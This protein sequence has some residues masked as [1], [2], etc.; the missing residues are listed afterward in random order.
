MKQERLDIDR[1]AF[2]GRTY[3]EYVR[4]FG[5]DESRLRRGPILDCPAGAASFAA[6]AGR[7][8]FDV[9]ACDM[10]YDL[11]PSELLEKGERDIRLIH[12]KVGEA[13]HMYVW[14]YYKNRN[15]LVAMRRKALAL[16][17]KDLTDGMAC[18]RYVKASLP[19]LPFADGSFPL[20]LSGH[21][22][23]LYGDLLDPDFHK[24]CLVEL[25]R[26]SSGEVRIFPLSGLDARPYP[27]LAEIRSFLGSNGVEVEIS[28][29]AFEFQRGANSMMRLHKN[30]RKKGARK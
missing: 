26:V 5:L 6:E 23:F 17:T 21:F 8:G 29:S 28:R 7:S 25:M 30:T 24:A 9:V 20:V 13:S 16:F 22:L 27:H 1:V 11:P 2:I 14:D 18:G 4:I 15:A 12:D 19:R 10:L 3:D